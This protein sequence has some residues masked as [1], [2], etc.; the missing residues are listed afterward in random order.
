MKNL[1]SRAKW[2]AAG[3]AGASAL[4]PLR[5]I[6]L[7]VPS[8]IYHP[9]FSGGVTPSIAIAETETKTKTERGALSRSPGV[10]CLRFEMPRALLKN[11]HLDQEEVVA[12]G[13]ECGPFGDIVINSFAEKCEKCAM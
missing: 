4:W 7:Q 5:E 1:L 13:A 9:P 6:C 2:R 12:W 3:A 11:F 10:L 8:T